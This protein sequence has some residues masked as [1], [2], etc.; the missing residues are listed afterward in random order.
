MSRNGTRK[1]GASM[2]LAVSRNPRVIVPPH[3]GLLRATKR[4]SMADKRKG[5]TTNFSGVIIRGDIGC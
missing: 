2:R 4:P 5:T 1:I 3:L